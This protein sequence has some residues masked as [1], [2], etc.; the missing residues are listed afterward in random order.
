MQQQDP[1]DAGHGKISEA[2]GLVHCCF[3]QALP[4]QAGR[5]LSSTVLTH[6]G[7]RWRLL[8]TPCH[9][10]LKCSQQAPSRILL[11]QSMTR[12]SI[13]W[14][15]LW[16]WL[17]DLT[18]GCGQRLRPLLVED[19]VPSS[20]LALKT[21]TAPLSRTNLVETTCTAG[22]AWVS[23]RCGER[24]GGFSVTMVKGFVT[25]LRTGFERP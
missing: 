9:L 4:N 2:G 21:T 14:S 5:R 15:S 17:A 24:S 6:L 16:E 3:L 19:S 8:P 11:Q 18:T 20:L 13:L 22:G 1:Y 10:S 12:K 25:P 23:P 7:K